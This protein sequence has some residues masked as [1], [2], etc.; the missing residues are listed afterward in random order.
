M[1]GGAFGER[2]TLGQTWSDV[3][4]RGQ[5]WSLG[6]VLLIRFLWLVGLIG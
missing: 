3:V 6:L 5:T 4:R 2:M 1:A